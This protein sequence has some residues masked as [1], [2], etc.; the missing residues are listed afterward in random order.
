MCCRALKLDVI[1]GDIGFDLSMDAIIGR[2]EQLVK[3]EGDALSERQTH[4]YNLQRKV[5]AL[6]EQLESRD[7]HIDLLRKKV[8]IDATSCKD[9]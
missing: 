4:I 8:N 7:L 2:A 1:A 9:I 5:K 3:M 6:K